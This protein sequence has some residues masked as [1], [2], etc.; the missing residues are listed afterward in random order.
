MSFE[1]GPNETVI[2][3]SALDIAIGARRL[4]ESIEN[5]DERVARLKQMF[6]FIPMDDIVQERFEIN[7]ARALPVS[8]EYPDLFRGNVSDVQLVGETSV[9]GKIFRYLYSEE[10]PEVNDLA[11]NV[12]N[13]VFIDFDVKAELGIQAV[14]AQIPLTELRFA[15]KL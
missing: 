10:D 3:S 8:P 4:V 14:I 11:L 2:G 9:P 7:A 1:V 12:L 13:P 5:V 6:S 15:T